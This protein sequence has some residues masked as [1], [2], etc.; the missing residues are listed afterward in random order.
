MKRHI[1]IVFGPEP[2]APTGVLT[3]E[4]QEPLAPATHFFRRIHLDNE[5][6]GLDRCQEGGAHGQLDAASFLGGGIRSHPMHNFP[7]DEQTITGLHN[8]RYGL[9]HGAALI[10]GPLIA[11]GNDT[12]RAVFVGELLQRDQEVD[13][14]LSALGAKRSVRRV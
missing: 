11:S 1:D 4:A 5:R 13:L 10:E 2:G 12:G 9:G 8:R 3:S 6:M 7:T 14:S